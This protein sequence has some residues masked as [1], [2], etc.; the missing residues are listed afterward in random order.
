[1][2]CR[3]GWALLFLCLALPP[4]G[5]G[6][7]GRTPYI[8]LA[9]FQYS[10]TG[11]EEERRYTESLAEMLGPLLP[12]MEILRRP[13]EGDFDRFRLKIAAGNDVPLLIVGGRIMKRGESYTVTVLAEDGDPEQPA[14]IFRY[15]YRDVRT[16]YQKQ[17]NVARSIR[18]AAEE[19]LARRQK[20]AD[21]AE[22]VRKQRRRKIE[23][24]EIYLNASGSYGAT[25]PD[26][27]GAWKGY[28]F[29][30]A[31]LSA[32]FEGPEAFYY[33]ADIE[34]A[35][36][37]PETPFDFRLRGDLG[38][39]LF[40]LFPLTLQAVYSNDSGKTGIQYGFSAGM[41]RF[42]SGML[43]IFGIPNLGAG[44]DLLRFSFLWDGS[45]GD[46]Q[47]QTRVISLSL[48]YTLYW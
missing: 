1:M 23:L 34:Y 48:A 4:A 38:V 10:G 47:V 19:C 46:F 7:A 30:T 17:L 24:W 11:P 14:R 39:S 8:I 25:A 15:Y 43:E 13:D 28:L 16:M 35:F 9:E 37:T 27:G 41:A 42:G 3:A 6:S 5:A 20:T 21:Y 12:D 36:G 45:T 29:P 44:L 18:T 26:G 31:G 32:V 2:N 40:F 22:Q 33:H